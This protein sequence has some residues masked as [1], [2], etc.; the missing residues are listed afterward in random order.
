MRRIWL[1]GLLSLAACASPSG[2]ALPTPHPTSTPSPPVI[3]A[4]DLPALAGAAASGPDGLWIADYDRGEVTHV[5]GG[6]SLHASNLRVGDPR[7]LQPGCQAGSVHYAPTGSFIIRRCD[8]PAGMA[9]GAGGVWTGRNDQQAVVRIDPRTGRVK[10]TIP[11][12]MHI[13]NL[14]ASDSV[15]IVDSYEDNLVAG[16]DPANN[17]VIWRET[18]LHSPSGIAFAA[19]SAWIALTGGFAVVRIDP[20]TGQV[21]ATVPVGH[22]PFPVVSA[23]GSVWVRCEQDSTVWRIDPASNRASNGI[24]VDPFYGND[25][26]DSMVGA[27]DGVWISG[28]SL[29]RIEAATGRLS[30]SLPVPGRPYDAGEGRIWVIGL[31]GR[32]SLVELPG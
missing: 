29:Q 13:F 14:A 19:G 25:G 27:G 24:P 1:L 4:L 5:S 6:S 15:V 18:V 31:G 20:T 21:L 23:A 11:V 2:S 32:L 9:V 3:A 17:R 26:L 10:A 7:S 8:L 28:L 12:R 16:I 30:G 22:K